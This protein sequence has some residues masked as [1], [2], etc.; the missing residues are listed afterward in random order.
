MI[1]QE[2][3]PDRI[4]QPNDALTPP[5]DTSPAPEKVVSPS[6]SPVTWNSPYTNELVMH[7]ADKN[8]EHL[9]KLA[10]LMNSPELKAYIEQTWTDGSVIPA[11]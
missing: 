9:V 11:F 10:G 4:P 6:G 3:F 1:V 5:A 2:H 7:T 8:N